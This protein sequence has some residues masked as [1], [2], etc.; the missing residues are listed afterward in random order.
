MRAA[1]RIADALSVVPDVNALPRRPVTPTTG[2][3]WPQWVSTQYD[4]STSCGAAALSEWQ[5]LLVIDPQRAVFDETLRDLIGDQLAVVGAVDSCEP[6]ELEVT[7]D[8]RTVPVVVWKMTIA[9]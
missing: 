3:V 1:Q 5:V 9:P 4:G 6:D 7:S 2:Q 8:G